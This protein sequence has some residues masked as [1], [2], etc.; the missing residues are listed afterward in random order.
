MGGDP[1]GPVTALDDGADI[2]RRQSL[3]G[4]DLRLCAAARTRDDLIQPAVRPDPDGTR[5]ILKDRRNA[6]EMKSVLRG[7]DR[8][9]PVLDA[10]EAAVE[11]ADPHAAVAG[12]GDRVDQIARK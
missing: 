2:H 1:H 7:I 6:V 10:V 9:L 11:C 12:L 3:D 8:Y 5:R 4:H